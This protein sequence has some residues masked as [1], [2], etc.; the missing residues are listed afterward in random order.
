MVR[1]AAAAWK[2]YMPSNRKKLAP[3]RPDVMVIP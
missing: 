1:A 3:K 2:P